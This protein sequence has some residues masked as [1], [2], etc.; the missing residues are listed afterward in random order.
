MSEEPTTSERSHLAFSWVCLALF[1][2][3][4]IGLEVLHAFKVSSYLDVQHSTRRLMW[5]LAHAHGTLLAILNLCFVFS[6]R[7][8]PSWSSSGR[9]LAAVCLRAAALLLPLGF[10]L[11][12]LHT[13]DGD[14]G[15]GVWLAP[16]GGMLMLVGVTA[17]AVAAWLQ[18]PRTNEPSDSSDGVLGG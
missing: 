5:R 18:R 14:P 7:L 17:T 2:L 3:M 1:V 10:F 16:V 13:Y 12:G 6:L 15:I 4:G 9:R 8:L 11:G